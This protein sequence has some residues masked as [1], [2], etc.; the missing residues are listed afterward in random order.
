MHVC[1]ATCY[2]GVAGDL[3]RCGIEFDGFFY[4]PNVHPLIEF[5]RRLKACRVLA[6][7]MGLPLSFDENYGL[8]Q[9]LRALIGHEQ[10]QDRCDICCRERLRR[11][12]E[13]ARD[14]GLGSF[15]T[16]L[17]SSPHQRHERLHEIGREVAQCVGVEFFYRDWRSTHEAACAQAARRSL[18][19]QQYCGCIYSEYERFRDTTRHLWRPPDGP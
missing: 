3:S 18:Y 14:A 2:L 15:T 10:E 16:T 12:A 17:L 4:N 7:E 19:R 11:T 6:H 9:W 13:A 8:V 1:C 5:R